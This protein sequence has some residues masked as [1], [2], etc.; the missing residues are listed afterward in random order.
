MWFNPVRSLVWDKVG[1]RLAVPANDNGLATFL[2]FGKEAGK[3]RF[4]LMDID[5][6]HA[7]K[8]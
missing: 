4:S 6:F 8:G 2:Y 1:D 3:I 7:A 5:R